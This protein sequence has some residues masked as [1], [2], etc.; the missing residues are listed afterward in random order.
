MNYSFMKLFSQ[1]VEVLTQCGDVISP[2]LSR[3][4]AQTRITFTN[5]DS[6]M[7]IKSKRNF[8]A[9]CWFMK[10]SSPNLEIPALCC[11]VIISTCGQKDSYLYIMY[12]WR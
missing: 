3:K 4:R 5:G 6:K 7:K 8:E 11:Y 1:N 10:L 9:R 12:N 2:K